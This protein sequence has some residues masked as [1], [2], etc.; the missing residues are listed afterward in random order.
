MGYLD[1]PFS[2]GQLSSGGL[3][4]AEVKLSSADMLSRDGISPSQYIQ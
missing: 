3:D 4:A 1:V 2:E